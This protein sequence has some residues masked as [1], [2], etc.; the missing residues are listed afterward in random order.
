MATFLVVITH[1]VGNPEIPVLLLHEI[2]L[3]FLTTSALISSLVPWQYFKI[4]SSTLAIVVLWN[5]LYLLIDGWAADYFM[6][7]F[8]APQ[9][10]LRVVNCAVTI[11]SYVPLVRAPKASYHRHRN[12]EVHKPTLSFPTWISFFRSSG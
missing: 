3:P 2:R 7:L 6:T 11:S 4:S 9:A 8:A 5:F 1:L 12:L 10:L